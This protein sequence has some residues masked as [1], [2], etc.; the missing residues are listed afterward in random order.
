LSRKKSPE[1]L[2]SKAFRDFRVR[3]AFLTAGKSRAHR[4]D[5]QALRT[6]F[7][8]EVKALSYLSRAWY[9]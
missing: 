9:M 4:H 2:Y 7:H 5:R 6:T 3:T 8:S 1:A